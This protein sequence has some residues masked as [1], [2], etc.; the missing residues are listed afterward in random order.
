M[1]FKVFLKKTFGK[2]LFSIKENDLLKQRIKIEKSVEGISD[3]I[4]GVQEKIQKLLLESKGQP[5]TLKLLNVQKIKALRLESGTKQQEANT[6][7]KQLQLILLVEAMRERQKSKTKSKLVDKILD[8][9]VEQLN[10]VL[11][12]MDI[13]KAFEE[14]RIDDVKERL[15]RIFA[16]EELP[17]DTESQELMKAI[18]DLEKV[19]EET[20][21][22]KAQEK[23][24]E[25]AEAPQKKKD[26]ELE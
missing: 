24:K 11:M 16:K 10:S 17:V 2:D 9:D 7:L 3:D 25:L 26:L 21:L 14:G 18:D 13:T 23:S 15:G 5:R 19:D 4:K 1:N 22:Q 12:D 20:A 8:T 6:L